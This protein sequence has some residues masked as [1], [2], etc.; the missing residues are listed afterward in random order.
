MNEH[1]ATAILAAAMVMGCANAMAQA[2]R[3]EDLRA[4]GFGVGIGK[5]TMS[6]GD[7]SKFDQGASLH[8]RLGLSPGD[9]VLL[10]AEIN[11]SRV[12]SPILDE[13]FRA[14]NLLLALSLG[15]NLRLRPSLG[16]QFRSWSGSERVESSDLGPLFGLD[17]GYE[18]KL[19]GNFSLFPEVIARCSVIQW[20]GGVN[21]SFVGVQ[22][23]GSWKQRNR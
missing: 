23:V 5:G 13:S 14:Y 7:K 20:D 6:V 22:V 10:M 9:H 12:T 3:Q 21:A 11:P 8:G 19:A 17:L 2:N 16:V 18:L 4:V 1:L 15:K